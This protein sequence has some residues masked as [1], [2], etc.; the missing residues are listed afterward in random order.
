MLSSGGDITNAGK[1]DL[2]K[3]ESV[4]IYATNAN[5]TNNGATPKGIFI[6]DEKSVGIYSKINSSSTADKIVTNSGKIDIDG[7]SK[8]GSAGIYSII[9]NGATKKLSTVNSGNITR[10][11]CKEQKYSS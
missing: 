1:I 5:V 11:L 3:K 4:G 10:N 8:T 2:E 6:K 9:E 7:T